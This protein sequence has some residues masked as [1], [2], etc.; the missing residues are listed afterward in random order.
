LLWLLLARSNPGLSLLFLPL[1]TSSFA[2]S[3]ASGTDVNGF[4]RPA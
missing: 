3:H 4:P 1:I 2:V